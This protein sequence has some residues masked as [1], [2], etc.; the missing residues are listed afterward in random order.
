MIR[1]TLALTIEIAAL[2]LVPTLASHAPAE[3]LAFCVTLV[4]LGFWATL[5]VKFERR[6]R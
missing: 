3:L 5:L 4:A 6:F 1:T 2:W